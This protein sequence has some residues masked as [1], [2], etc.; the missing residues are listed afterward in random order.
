MEIS[1]STFFNDGP[2]DLGP[3]PVTLG[4]LSG[5]TTIDFGTDDNLLILRGVIRDGT[6][7]SALIKQGAGR[8]ML[9]GA[10]TYSGGTIINGYY[11]SGAVLTVRHG[12]G[13][14][15]GSVTVNQNAALTLR[16]RRRTHHLFWVTH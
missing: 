9:A 12:S 16:E 3:G 5:T 8:L 14:G 7:A 6:T 4:T 13:L 10:N 2:I 15:T 11:F 1:P